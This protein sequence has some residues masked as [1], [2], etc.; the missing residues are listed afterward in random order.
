MKKLHIFDIDDCIFRPLLRK[1]KSNEILKERFENLI[2]PDKIKDLNSKYG[3]S[4]YLMKNQKNTKLLVRLW[5]DFFLSEKSF[6]LNNEILA[7]PTPFVIPYILKLV[8]SSDDKIMY[9][10]GRH[11][12]LRDVTDLQLRSV[13]LPIESLV[14]KPNKEISD[15]FFKIEQFKK[16]VKMNYDLFIIYEDSPT[17]ITNFFK[18]FEESSILKSFEAIALLTTHKEEE[19]QKIGQGNRFRKDKIKIVRD[20]K[21]I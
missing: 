17:H 16:I 18:I 14:L 12:E 6:E 8:N 4:E 15:S 11:E 7:I 20:F 10:S 21:E 1:I 13:G 19:F 9:L 5:L 2:L 3:I